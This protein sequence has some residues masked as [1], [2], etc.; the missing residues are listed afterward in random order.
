MIVLNV[1]LVLVDQTFGSFFIFIFCVLL[2][3]N[4]IVK[5]EAKFSGERYFLFGGCGGN[6]NKFDSREECERTCLV[7][8]KFE[9]RKKIFDITNWEKISYFFN[10]TLP[11]KARRHF[12]AYDGLF[13]IRILFYVVPAVGRLFT[14]ADRLREKKDNLQKT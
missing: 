8:I 4:L 12:A 14:S 2:T 13:C 9:I 5:H 6:G 7:S 11:C 1:L 10:K 3:K